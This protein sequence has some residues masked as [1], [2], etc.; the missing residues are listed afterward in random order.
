MDLST[1][2][3]SLRCA[4]AAQALRFLSC[5]LS[6]DLKRRSSRLKTTYAWQAWRELVTV[7]VSSLHQKLRK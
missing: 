2:G 7:E 1:P 3:M 5:D 6:E 4:E